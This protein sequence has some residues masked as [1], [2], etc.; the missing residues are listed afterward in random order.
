MLAILGAEARVDVLLHRDLWL[1]LALTWWMHSYCK[2]DA[3][4]AYPAGP[5]SYRTR[6]ESRSVQ[7]TP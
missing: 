6:L 1:N 2:P 4:P 7:R 3:A 5:R